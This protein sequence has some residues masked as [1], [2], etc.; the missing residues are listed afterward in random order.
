MKKTYEKNS[1]FGECTQLNL[2]QMKLY[3]GWGKMD[4]TLR[5]FAGKDGAS[6]M[7]S[8]AARVQGWIKSLSSNFVY[9]GQTLVIL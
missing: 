5:T 8:E 7:S 9:C 2:N 4:L 1:K 6:N 3:K